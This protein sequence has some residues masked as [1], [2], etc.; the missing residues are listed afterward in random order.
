M[1]VA[2]FSSIY[3]KNIKVNLS[4]DLF[5]NFELLKYL[6]S[7]FMKRKFDRHLIKHKLSIIILK[8]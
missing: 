7:F 4:K 5:L 3:F 1:K 2:R 6:F 8:M